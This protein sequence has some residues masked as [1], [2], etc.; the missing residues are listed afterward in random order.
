MGR[1]PRKTAQKARSDEILK[2]LRANRRSIERMI[3]QTERQMEKADPGGSPWRQC[4][5]LVAQLSA[6]LVQ[7]NKAIGRTLQNDI[8]QPVRG[9]AYKRSSGTDPAVSRDIR[10]A[11]KRVGC[12]PEAALGE[13]VIV[14][15]SETEAAEE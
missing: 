3:R 5:R 1:R 15:R 10:A 11:L 9:L 6:S 12:V 13:N 8:M 4:A 2:S 14:L 7:A